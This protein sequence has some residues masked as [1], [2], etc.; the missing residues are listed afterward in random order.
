LERDLE[1]VELKF[2]PSF[3]LEV[4]F[5]W[6]DRQQPPSDRRPNV[7]LVPQ[8]GLPAGMTR[9]TLGATPKAIYDKPGP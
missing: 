2:V 3:E 7:M 5:D 6:G 1:N 9:M 4:T 8:S